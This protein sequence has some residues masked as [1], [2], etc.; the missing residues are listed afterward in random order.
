MSEEP[1]V[2]YELVATNE[3]LPPPPQVVVVNPPR[4]SDAPKSGKFTVGIGV[5]V[6]LGTVV[7]LAIGIGRNA[8]TFV[9]S[10]GLKPTLENITRLDR[11]RENHA[12]TLQDLRRRVEEL[13]RE[14][15]AKR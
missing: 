14:C 8:A 7:N 13:E 3:P 6:A 5:I 11:E 4:R 15:H 2:E 9:T 1:R 10:D 12:I